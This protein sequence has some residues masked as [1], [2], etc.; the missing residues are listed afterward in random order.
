[1]EE[2]KSKALDVNLAQTRALNIEIPE[3]FQDFIGMSSNYF[4]INNRSQEFV[5]EY[6]HPYSNLDTTIKM[7][8]ELV[9][10]DFWFFSKP[11]HIEKSFGLFREVFVDLS[12]KDLA[13]VQGELLLSTVLEFL[14]A[15][16]KLDPP[17]ATHVENFLGF[18]E[19]W[20]KSADIVFARASGIYRQVF[21]EV[22]K[23]CR[24]VGVQSESGE[25]VEWCSG[26]SIRLVLEANLLYWKETTQFDQWYSGIKTADDADLSSLLGAA[27]YD[28]LIAEL[29]TNPEAVNRVPSYN[30]LAN[31]HRLQIQAFTS[32]IRR[33]QYIFYL[34]TLPCMSEIYTHLLFD[35]NRLLR[36]INTQLSVDEFISFFD[37]FFLQ[38]EAYRHSHQDSILDCLFTIGKVVASSPDKQLMEAWLD[39]LISFGFVHPS[40]IRIKA[41]WQLETDKNHIKNIRIWLELISLSPQYS[42]RLLSALIVNLRIGGVFIA[43]TDLFQKDVSTFLN[44]G[45]VRYWKQVQQLLRLFPV[46]FSEIGAEGEIRD[47]TTTM[48]ELTHRRDRLIHFLRKQVH[49]ESNNTH[50]ILV[51]SI[52]RFWDR[53]GEEGCRGVGVQ[54]CS[55]V[56]QHADAAELMNACKPGKDLESLLPADILAEL[57][58][59]NPGETSDAVLESRKMIDALN[60][61]KRDTGL[62]TKEIM[63]NSWNQIEPRFHGYDFRSDIHL[64]KLYLILR[65][66][67]LLREKYQFHSSDIIRHL[68]KYPFF[69]QKELQQLRRLLNHTDYDNS[70]RYLL[71]LIERLNHMVRSPKESVGWE[72][73]Y[74]KRHIAAG[75]PSMYGQYRENKFEALGLIF[76]LEAVVGTLMAKEISTINLGYITARTLKRII[77]TLELFNKGLQLDGISNETFES[78]LQMLRYS[79][80]S[81]NFSIDQYINVFSFLEESIKEIISE[82]FYRSFD[83]E[84]HFVIPQ[85]YPD[86]LIEG[87]RG[88][89]A[90]QKKA[91]EFYRNMLSSAFLI[92]DLDNFI[93]RILVSLRHMKQL[94]PPE[95]LLKVMNYDPDQVSTLLHKKDTR[96]DNQV[97]LGAKAYFLKKLSQL[98][99]PIPGG[100]VLTTELF[101][102]RMAL[103]CHPEMSQEMDNIIRQRLG[104]LENWTGR[105]FGSPKNPL[106]LSV[107][108]GGAISMPGAM[109]TFLNI[110]L[111]DEITENL[112]HE[113]NFHWTAWDS[114]R[115]LLQSWG[116][117]HEIDRDVF[118]QIMIDYKEKYDVDQKTS[119]S[120]AQMKQMAMDYKAVLTANDVEL[121]QDPFEQM[122]R[123][124]VSVLDSW[125]TDRAILYRKTMQIADEWGTAVVCQQM[126]FGNISLRSGSGVVF[127]HNSSSKVPGISLNGDF[128]ICSQG[129][130]VV[131]GLVYTLPISEDQRLSET[132]PLEVS[133][134]KDFP[135]IY[136]RLFRYARRLVEDLG[137]SHQEIEFTF[138]GDEGDDLFILQIRDQSISKERQLKVFNITDENKKQV[139]HGIGIGNGVLN[140]RIVFDEEDI[141]ALKAEDPTASLILVR[142]DTVPDDIDLIVQ[143][144]G[145]LTSRGG[146]TS[147]A[148]VTATRMNKIGVVNCRDM[149]VFEKEKYCQIGE[150]KLPLGAKIAI[151]GHNG[152]IYKGWYQINTM[153]VS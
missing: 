152:S 150:T 149:S 43:D 96:L 79:I 14:L 132:D 47:V 37:T 122:K 71:A 129:E 82:Y 126:V 148:A 59:T 80:N 25:V 57:S 121:V 58:G 15:I 84:L 93:S 144:D 31:Y 87:M 9:L 73:I 66:H 100:F 42:M 30:D 1:M 17:Q 77:R 119:F 36:E 75:I 97:F 115:R 13:P 40:P 123:A 72:N 54:G 44:S 103:N 8:R 86:A 85:L 124:I 99:F 50:I 21:K 88:Q 83:R 143:C 112:S 110:G 4:G 91:E 128:T 78:D 113:P 153:F 89:T 18:I 34:L 41:D 7:L 48:D 27:Y 133:L 23:G 109:N 114:Y 53:C 56:E 138:Q 12:A 65:L 111:N 28:R 5:Q 16:L 46:F 60:R 140:G 19:N 61:F 139:G 52:L 76:R 130:D 94:F 104:A 51:E 136:N 26:D 49:T 64:H 70:I 106:L 151:D 135:N 125:D 11:E 39:H 32:D 107:R 147:H 120:P 74:Y 55:D 142:P 45:S 81:S 63:E 137:Y 2:I 102:H 98:Q 146:A 127:T 67:D 134:E 145:L 38:I 92:Q 116:M 62:G 29:E 33:I 101:R 24:G 35:L 10:T 20:R 68:E 108:S 141:A 131:A 118:D 3:H 95:I 69:S 105:K 22:V 117:S 6:L 90:Y